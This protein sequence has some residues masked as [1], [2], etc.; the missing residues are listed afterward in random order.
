M[1]AVHTFQIQV[2]A[3]LGNEGQTKPRTA[4]EHQP[5]ESTWRALKYYVNCSKAHA[6]YNGG[7]AHSP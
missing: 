4:L 1:N 3:F 5:V 7:Q 6:G 2:P